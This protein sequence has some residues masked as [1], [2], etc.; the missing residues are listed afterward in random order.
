M[1]KRSDFEKIKR[2]FYPTPYEA[3]VPLFS[4]LGVVRFHEPCFGKGDLAEA[5]TS[6]GHQLGGR[7]DIAW[8][9]DALDLTECDG[10]CFVTNPPYTW[11]ILN[12]LITH[13][14][15]IAPT[16]LLLPADMMHNKRMAPHMGRCARIVS[17]GRVKW[18]DNKSGM[19]NSAWYLFDAESTKPAE[20]YG[21]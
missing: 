19:E 7:G 8:G 10:D 2:D 20:F 5:L 15:D 18:F 1:G 17:V 13:L 4:H 3:V 9:E 16:W 11:S 14:S 6:Y 12:P 21:R